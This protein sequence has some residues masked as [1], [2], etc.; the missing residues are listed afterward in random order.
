MAER[1]VVLGPSLM[2]DCRFAP[3]P[4]RRIVCIMGFRELLVERSGKGCGAA[5]P[6]ARADQCK[7]FGNGARSTS[8]AG[9]PVSA[10]EI[11]AKRTAI[12]TARS[13]GQ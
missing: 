5:S 8:V 13:R 2:I 6:C 10:A 12:S 3:A 1:V 9:F 11:P 4:S 7:E